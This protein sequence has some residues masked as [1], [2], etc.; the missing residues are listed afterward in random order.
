VQGS[1]LNPVRLKF[2]A[3]LRDSIFQ[4]KVIISE[5]NFLRFFP[6]QE[7]YKFF[8]LESTQPL[9]SDPVLPLKEALADYGVSIERSQER[10]A[11][12][13]RVENTYLSTFQSLG[14]LGLILGTIGLA[15][16]LLRNVLERRQEL[17][18]LRAVG[19]RMRVLTTIILAENI[20]LMLWGLFTG[21]ACALLA[22]LP[23]LFTRGAT[24]PLAIATY[25]ILAVLAAGLSASIFAVFTAFRSPLLNALRSE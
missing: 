2:V 17:A 20:F 24:V 25:V 18:L 21:T 16:V 3:L 7:G 19:Y 15:S 11:A 10:L 14:T 23:A 1:R 13:H 9:I 4:G 5:S 8:L 22:V 12:F 6:E